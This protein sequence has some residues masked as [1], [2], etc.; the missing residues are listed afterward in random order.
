MRGQRSEDV[1]EE[2]VSRSISLSVS[3]TSRGQTHTASVVSTVPGGET[4]ALIRRAIAYQAN[5]L[6]WESFPVPEQGRIRA[7]GTVLNQVTEMPSWLE[8]AVLED[9]DLLLSI[10]EE[11]EAHTLRYFH[12]DAGQG[13]GAEE[14]PRVVVTVAG[15]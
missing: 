14:A 8:A 3:Y 7:I 10:Y 5:G 15:R 13:E 11:V 1:E 6:S 2:L 9:D 12:G 4:K